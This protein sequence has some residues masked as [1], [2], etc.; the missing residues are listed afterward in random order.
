MFGEREDDELV[1]SIDG[2]G[3]SMIVS[4]KKEKGKKKRQDEKEKEKDK[5]WVINEFLIILFL[6]CNILFLWKSIKQNLSTQS[7][8][9]GSY[10]DLTGCAWLINEGSL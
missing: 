8:G 3:L 4:E 9:C 5:N 1:E 7:H 2:M 10:K 6:L